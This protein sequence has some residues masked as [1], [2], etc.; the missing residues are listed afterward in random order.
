MLHRNTRL[1]KSFEIRHYG[2]RTT[3][4]KLGYTES[5]LNS[6][7]FLNRSSSNLRMSKMLILD[8]RARDMLCR[9]H[10]FRGETYE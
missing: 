6:L 7:L 10:V 5:L 8:L 3:Y 1:D 2:N 4:G 9:K